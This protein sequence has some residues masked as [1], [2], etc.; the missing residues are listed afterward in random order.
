MK[1]TLPSLMTMALLLFGAAS[2]LADDRD[3]RYA[4]GDW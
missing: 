4:R 3:G 1:K 2:V